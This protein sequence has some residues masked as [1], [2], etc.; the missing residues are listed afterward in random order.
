MNAKFLR[1]RNWNGAAL[2]WTAV[3]LARRNGLLP[4]PNTFYCE[5]CA[6]TAEVYDHRDYNQPLNVGP[7]CQPCNLKREDAKSKVWTKREA[8]AYATRLF[9]NERWRT[10]DGQRRYALLLAET[11]DGLVDAQDF[12]SDLFPELAGMEKAA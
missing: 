5:D 4:N 3:R 10:E 8:V 6:K 7:V 11:S 2:A 12:A 1:S 9:S